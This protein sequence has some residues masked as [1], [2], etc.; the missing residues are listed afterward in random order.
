[1]STT[2]QYETIAIAKALAD[3]KSHPVHKKNLSLM[4]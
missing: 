2:P 4:L 3:P 1:M